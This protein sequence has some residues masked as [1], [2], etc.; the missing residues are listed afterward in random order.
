MSDVLIK[1]FPNVRVVSA[2]MPQLK[3]CAICGRF[4]RAE[5]IFDKPKVYIWACST[6]KLSELKKLPE[7]QGD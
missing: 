7:L 6:H 2:D 4:T 5:W 3:T 1:K